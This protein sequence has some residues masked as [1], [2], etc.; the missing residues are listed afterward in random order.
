MT[1][2]Y[3]QEFSAGQCVVVYRNEDKPLLVIGARWNDGGLRWEYECKNADGNTWWWR[4][5]V[6]KPF[7]LKQMNKRNWIRRVA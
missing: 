7:R 4:D 2:P 3:T 5:D 6:L 1:A